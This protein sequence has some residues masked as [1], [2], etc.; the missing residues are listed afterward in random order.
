MTSDITPTNHII[1]SQEITLRYIG[2]KREDKDNALRKDCRKL[3]LK[4]IRRI[5]LLMPRFFQTIYTSVIQATVNIVL[6]SFNVTI[7]IQDKI[8]NSPEALFFGFL[9]DN[10]FSL[11][12]T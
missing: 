12:R 7:R 3:I 8:I 11:G 4:G 5:L 6:D 10:A 9:L 2:D 1:T